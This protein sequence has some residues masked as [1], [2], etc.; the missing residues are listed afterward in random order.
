MKEEYKEQDLF[1][2]IKEYF[3]SYGYI[4][5][6]EVE[7]IDLY[8]EKGEVSV[9][10]ELKKTLDFKALQQAALR[11]KITDYVYIGIFKP[12]DLYRSS[13]QDKL[14][15]C[16]RLG[17]GVIVVSKRSKALEIVAEPVVTELSVF[18]KSNKNKKTT[19]LKEF[20]KRKTKS[21]TGG[22]HGTK[23][24][25]SYREEALLVLDTLLSLGGEATTREVRNLCK[26][27]KTTKIL[28]QNYYGWFEKTGTGR[29]EVTE[30]GLQAVEEFEET[31]RL[32][33]KK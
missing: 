21:N 18:Q 14:Y 12:A 22:V 8:M 3:E 23:L 28:Y 16:K 6:G 33:H 7:D 31:L 1:K 4:C 10:V 17:I 11:Q 30:L 26:V 25:T 24:I 19:L 2:P 9:A 32:L 20:Q 29:Y 5:D 13:F 15:L 27:E